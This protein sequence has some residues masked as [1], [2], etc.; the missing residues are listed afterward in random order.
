[1]ETVFLAAGVAFLLIGVQSMIIAF[2]GP[3]FEFDW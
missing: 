1:L 3:L 2:I